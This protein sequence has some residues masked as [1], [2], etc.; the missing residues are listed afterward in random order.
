MQYQNKNK[1]NDIILQA[2][3]KLVKSSF[4]VFFFVSICI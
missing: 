1:Y 4:F 2:S 3:G